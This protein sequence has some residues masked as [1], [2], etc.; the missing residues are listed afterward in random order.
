[1]RLNGISRLYA[2]LAGARVRACARAQR[3]LFGRTLSRADLFELICGSGGSGGGGGDGGG[4]VGG[5]KQVLLVVKAI[6]C[7]ALMR[8]FA[9][10]SLQK[11]LQFCQSRDQKQLKKAD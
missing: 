7:A 6:D 2:A 1:M 3:S 8:V 9:L 5:A 4:D 10:I 11:C